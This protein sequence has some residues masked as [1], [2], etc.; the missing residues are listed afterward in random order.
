MKYFPE[1]L[2]VKKNWKLK[3]YAVGIYI[4]VYVVPKNTTYRL[5]I[6]FGKRGRRYDQS[7]NREVNV[8][9]RGRCRTANRRTGRARMERVRDN[10]TLRR[11]FTDPVASRISLIT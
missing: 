3:T 10:E 7:R 11:P 2:T 8:N 6:I 4:Y 5:V 9:D 1:E